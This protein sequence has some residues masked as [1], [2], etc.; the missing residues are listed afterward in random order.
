MKAIPNINQLASEIATKLVENQIGGLATWVI[1][2]DGSECF[3]EQGQYLFDEIYDIVYN[4]L[5]QL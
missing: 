3:T 2:L 4:K 5:I 1:T